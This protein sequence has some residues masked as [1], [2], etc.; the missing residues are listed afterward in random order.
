[1]ALKQYWNTLSSN[2]KKGFYTLMVALAAIAIWF[3][4][5]KN[6]ADSPASIKI[7]TA[8]KGD[9]EEVVTAQ[10]KLEPKEYV[11]VGTQVSGQLK[12]L[13]VD[14]GSDV[15][16]DQLLAE[17]DPRLYESRYEAD[18]AQLKSYQAQLAEQEADLDLARKQQARNDQL[19]KTQAISKD[20]NDISKAALASAQ[21][22]VNTQKAQIEQTESTIKGD[23]A[24]L[25]YTKIF[26]PMDG[27]VVTLPARQGQT[28]N[29]NQ[30][31]PTILQLANL[32][33][34]TIRAQVAEADVMRLKN[35]MPVRFT[36]LGSLEK[37]WEAKVRQILPTP[38]V[39]NDVVLYNV[40]ID[41]DNKKRI[42]MNGMSTQIFFELDSAQDVLTIP[43]EA[44]GRHLSKQDNDAGLA[45]MV[46]RKDG[47]DVLVRIGLMD[48]TNAQVRDGLSEGD[49]IQIHIAPPAGQRQSGNR[50]GGA[51]MGG[52]RL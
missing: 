48:R 22:R 17:I 25:E 6:P 45:Y 14:I 5:H 16:K 41:V 21:A 23:K 30:T 36:T 15:K 24:N 28:L 19:I 18:M 37:K 34:M 46:K 33:V 39:I 9:I 49:E 35:D 3:G 10:G 32:D 31:A 1:M 44:L 13:H 50:S 52:P 12:V 7:V 2:R 27:T 4:S 29:A 51:M 42:L 8:Q 47:S 11:D 43:L 40:L 26:A 20:A 38:E